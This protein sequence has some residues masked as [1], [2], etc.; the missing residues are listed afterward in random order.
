MATEMLTVRVPATIANMGPGFDSF[1][2]AVSLYNRFVFSGADHDALVFS[3]ESTVKP[4]GVEAE[5]GNNIL[6]AAMDRL[7]ARI[8]RERPPCHVEVA[9]DIPVARGLGSSSTA[10]VAAL[11]A[12]NRMA[13]EPLS[14]QELL[15]IA[16]EIE[17]HP[18]NVAPTMLGGVVLYDTA[19][20]VL[21]WP[22]EWRVLVLS[23]AYPV[24]TEEARRI[25]PQAISHDDAVY[26][27]RKASLLTY[28]LLREDPDAF[29][30]SLHDR[31]HQPYRRN[32]IKEYDAIEQI[33]LDVGAF[34]MVISGSGSSMAV[35]YP[36]VIHASLRDKLEALIRDEN[37]QMLVNDVSVDTE[38][39]QL[40]P[41]G[42]RI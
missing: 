41:A 13:G 37:W 27:L 25:L 26:N 22:I 10:V 3:S 6:F 2:M 7:Y 15:D 16:I 14:R 21:P 4:R 33:V 42:N 28:A 20:Y 18:D 12:A 38:G 23:P 19:P 5:G 39:A 30:A 40:L 34:G 17:G 31:L 11:V 1:G 9:A 24:L 36:T 8:G 29:R 35:F 32:L